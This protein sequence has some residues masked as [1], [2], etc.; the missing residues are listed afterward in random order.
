MICK[1]AK[2][3]KHCTFEFG[4]DLKPVAR[5]VLQGWQNCLGKSCDTKSESLFQTYLLSF[6][7]HNYQNQTGKCVR[8]ERLDCLGKAKIE[9][10][11]TSRDISLATRKNN[12]KELQKNFQGWQKAG[13]L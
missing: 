10:S 2:A 5:P 3:W 8:K 4:M 6:C 12:N 1:Y 7:Y 13:S 11:Q 9:I